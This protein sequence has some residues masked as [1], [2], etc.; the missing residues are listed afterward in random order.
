MISIFNG[1]ERGLEESSKQKIFLQVQVRMRRYLHYFGPFGW[2][3]FTAI[4]LHMDE[5]G[6]SW[7]GKDLLSDETGLAVKTIGKWIKRLD[8]LEIKGRRVLLHFQPKKK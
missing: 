8:K 7:P 4:A 6:W 5:N 2:T 3:V 1:S